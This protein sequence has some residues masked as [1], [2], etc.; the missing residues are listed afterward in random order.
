MGG[1]IW[2]KEFFF[3]R[4]TNIDGGGIAFCKTVLRSFGQDCWSEEQWVNGVGMLCTRN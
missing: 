2:P 4:V 3:F 1:R